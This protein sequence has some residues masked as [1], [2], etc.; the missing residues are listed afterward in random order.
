MVCRVLE[1][2]VPGVCRFALALPEVLQ[3]AGVASLVF[4]V[5]VLGRPLLVLLLRADV[6]FET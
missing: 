4:L 1:R 6:R 5:A 2:E 3:A